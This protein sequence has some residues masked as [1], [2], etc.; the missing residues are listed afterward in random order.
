MP[1]SAPPA[2]PPGDPR[3]DHSS[4]A[5][6]LRGEVYRPPE[7]LEYLE[8]AVA[9]MRVVR[10]IVYAGLTSFIVLAI[11]GFVLIYRLTTDVHAVVQQ[12]AVMTQQMQAMARSMANLNQSVAS[13]SEDVG[14]LRS[15]VAE[16]NGSVAAMTGGVDRMAEAVTLMQHSVRNI[17]TSVGPAMGAVN[18]FMPFGWGGSTYPGPPPF[19]R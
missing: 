14:S 7:Y 19:A 8:K 18:R 6:E 16:M 5:A 10:L 9:A 2:S 3:I 1:P 17:D 15:T 13:L 4:G 11:Y 12:T